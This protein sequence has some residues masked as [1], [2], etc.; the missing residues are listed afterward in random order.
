MDKEMNVVL[1][2]LTTVMAIISLYVMFTD[3]S[4]GLLFVFIISIATPIFLLSSDNTKNK[5]YESM[6]EFLNAP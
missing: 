2:F 4:I 5:V 6:D 1:G 3:F